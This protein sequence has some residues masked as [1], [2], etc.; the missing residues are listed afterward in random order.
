[1]YG[2]LEKQSFEPVWHR[3]LILLVRHSFSSAEV[4]R[5]LS[6]VIVVDLEHSLH[7]NFQLV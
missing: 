4:L 3:P 1:L 5:R 2:K 6:H 7:L